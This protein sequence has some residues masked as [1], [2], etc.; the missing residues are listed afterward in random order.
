MSFASYT[1]DTLPDAVGKAFH[2]DWVRVEQAMID[3]FAEATLDSDPMHVDP[4]WA[5][6]VGPFGTTVA[7]GFQ[8]LGLLTHFAREIGTP[9]G[10]L[11]ELNYGIEH[12]RFIAPVPVASLLRLRMELSEIKQREDSNVLAIWHCTVEIQGEERPALVANWLNLFVRNP[13]F[14]QPPVAE[15]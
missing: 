12:L 4:A 5:R 14:N 15:A 8:T 11:Y 7:F 9:A 1:L 2:S 6:D 13:D 10:A 3:R